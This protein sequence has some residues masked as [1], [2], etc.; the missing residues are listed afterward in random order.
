[1]VCGPLL[2]SLRTELGYT[3]TEASGAAG[4]CPPGV[5]A[6]GTRV[7]KKTRRVWAEALEGPRI[8]K[9]KI[10]SV[11]RCLGISGDCSDTWMSF[12]FPTPLHLSAKSCPCLG[13]HDRN[14]TF[15]MKETVAGIDSV[16]CL[17][18]YSKLERENLNSIISSTGLSL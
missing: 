12:Q 5:R 16:I 7:G 9:K 18:L 6:S 8:L 3:V 4:E 17:R 1:M 2:L 15:T 13:R 14:L 10:P 11:P